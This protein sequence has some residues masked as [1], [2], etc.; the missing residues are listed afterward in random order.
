MGGAHQSQPLTAPRPRRAPPARSQGGRIDRTRSHDQTPFYF[1]SLDL[2]KLFCFKLLLSWYFDVLLDTIAFR[3]VEV[4]DMDVKTI[5][6]PKPIRFNKSFKFF[7]I[8]LG[9]YHW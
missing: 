8:I 6:L 7:Q 5:K 3:L 2:H 1:G 9:L 4:M